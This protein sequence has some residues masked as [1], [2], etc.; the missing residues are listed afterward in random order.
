MEVPRLEG[1]SE[2]QLPA[3][4]TAIP[5]LDPSHLC[6]LHHSSQQLW[7]LNPLREYRD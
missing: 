3:N 6:N 7:N 5:I 2:L 4:D 1:E